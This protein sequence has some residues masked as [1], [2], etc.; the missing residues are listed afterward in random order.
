MQSGTAT[1][2]VVP[3][4]NS[5]YGSVYQTLD[6][7]ADR[8]S[9]FSSLAICGEIYLGIHHSLLGF[10]DPPPTSSSDKNSLDPDE[11]N[12]THLATVPPGS[13]HPPCSLAHVRH[14]Y[15]HPQALGQCTTFLATHL[16]NAQP[17]ET[18]STSR[19]AKDAAQ[20]ASL[21]SAAIASKAVAGDLGLEVLVE[22]IEDRGDNATR[23]LVLRHVEGKG[24][25]GLTPRVLRTRNGEDQR[26][27]WRTMVTFRAER[28][29]LT[30]ALGVF[31]EAG[32]DV[33]VVNSRPSHERPWHY[34]FFV[35]FVGRLEEDQTGPVR[36][37]IGKL[38]SI[39]DGGRLWG[40]WRDGSSLSER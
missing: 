28:G 19:G 17:H 27:G 24:D 15:S 23:F 18:T 2:G 20:D 33:T 10:Q 34:V 37:A 12:P 9:Q 13:A 7:L 26:R 25:E 11:A 8:Q 36:E 5:T 38:E 32:L 29:A 21:G 22:G 1:Y 31:K 4:E 3:F 35:E 39:T 16:S 14:V 40:S 30:E 6:L